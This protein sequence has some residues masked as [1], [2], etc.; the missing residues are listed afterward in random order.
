MSLLKKLKRPSIGQII[1]WIITVALAAGAFYFVRSF[2]TCW[3][4]TR[5]PGIAPA[6]CGTSTVTEGPVLNEEG[7][8]VA[9]TEVAELPPPP[10]EIPSTNLP[11]P[12]DG[13]SRV[14]ILFLGLDERDWVEGLG[15]PRS[16][17]MI[18]FT[19]DP[20]T[21]TAG[22]ITIPRD[23]WVN[24]PGLGTAASIRRIPLVK[25]TNSPAVVPDWR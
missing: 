14:N 17:T 11:E 20:L 4:T 6:S 10:I 21:K 13:A 7:T 5:L 3:T 12:W 23:L 9:E 8:P 15:A 16:D 24:I 2:T 22:M 19:V 18:L 1:F 25:G